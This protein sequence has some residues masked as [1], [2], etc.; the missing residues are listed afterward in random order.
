MKKKSLNIH[1]HCFESFNDLDASD[2]ELVEVATH[3]MSRAYAP[4]SEFQ[5]GAA[6]RMDDNSIVEGNNQE[7]V[8][9]PSGLCA[10]R[11]ALFYAGAQF[12]EK[13]DRKS[14]CRERV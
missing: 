11:V 7:N 9:Y 4:Y 1:Y 3:A 12:P 10:E 6:L 13:A 5:V 2:R 14:V 8:A